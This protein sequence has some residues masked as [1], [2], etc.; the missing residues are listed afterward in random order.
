MSYN[1]VFFG[2]SITEGSS[3]S[4]Y[5]K[6]YAAI[7]SQYIKKL[8]INDEVNI[9]NAGISGPTSQYGLFRLNRDVLKYEP[10]LIFIEFAVND[11][12]EDP[13]MVSIHMEGIIRQLLKLEKIPTIVMLITPTQMADA[14]AGIHKKIAYYYNVPVID[15]QDYIWREIGEGKYRWPKLA[16]DNL[17]PNDFGHELYGTYITKCLESEINLNHKPVFKE[18]TLMNYSLI[19]P[20]LISYEKLIFYGHWREETV[21]IS[22]KIEMA[23]VSDTPGDCLEFN[24]KGRYFSMYNLVGNNC[25]IIDFSIDDVNYNMDLYSDSQS[26]PLFTI[27]LT[28]LPD[29]EHR[30]ILRISESKNANSTGHKVAIGYL[31][32]DDYK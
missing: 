3:A 5:N 1:V 17:H 19:N 2:G 16:V 32:V 15:I 12:I 31:L 13:L 23:A 7:V 9:Y 8:H 25:G 22:K 28:D 24:F 29:R 20:D 11:R 21:G 18:K 26:T 14:C 10:N 6:S 4:N 27:N 30:F